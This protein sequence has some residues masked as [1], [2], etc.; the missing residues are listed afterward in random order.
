MG[1]EGLIKKKNDH[2]IIVGENIGKSYITS[3]YQ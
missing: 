1:F 2:T 3:L